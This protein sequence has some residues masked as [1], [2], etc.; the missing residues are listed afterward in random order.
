MRTHGSYCRCTD[1]TLPSE[2]EPMDQ[3][4]MACA[5]CQG[6]QQLTPLHGTTVDEALLALEDGTLSHGMCHEHERQYR[7]RYRLKARMA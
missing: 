7:E 5:W 2:R 3:Q 6:E 1:C 4:P